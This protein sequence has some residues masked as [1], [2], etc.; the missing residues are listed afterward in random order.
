[1]IAGL[2]T[3]ADA[4]FAMHTKMQA[5]LIIFLMDFLRAKLDSFTLVLDY[6]VAEI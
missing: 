2:L 6:A 4:E 3:A 5:A 1:M